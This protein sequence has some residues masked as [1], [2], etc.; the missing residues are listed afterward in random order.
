MSTA[1]STSY[2]GM[3]KQANLEWRDI[4]LEMVEDLKHDRYKDD[5]KDRNAEVSG[6]SR[7]SGTVVTLGMALR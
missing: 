3:A 7:N 6:S 5:T 1:A 2:L 4:S